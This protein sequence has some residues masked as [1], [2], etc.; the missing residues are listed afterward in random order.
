MKKQVV[1]NETTNIWCAQR[2]RQA[3]C[4][5]ILS[6]GFEARLDLEDIHMVLRYRLRDSMTVGKIY[7]SFDTILGD[8]PALGTDCNSA[9]IS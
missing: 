7:C 8:V 4:K 1:L 6:A 5:S 3:G 9:Y 2:H